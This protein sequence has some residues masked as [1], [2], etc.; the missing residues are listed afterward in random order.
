MQA[1]A[2]APLSPVAALAARAATVRTACG[3]GTAVWRVWGEGP[4]V[5]LLHGASG[6]WTHWLRNIPALAARFRVIVPDMPGYGDSAAPPEPTAECLA[7][8]LADG[9]D[10]VVGPAG[11]VRLAGF[12]C[13]G[14]VAGLVAARP[15]RRAR[16]LVLVGPNGLA[17]PCGEMAPLRRIDAGMSA[18][19]VREAHRANLTILMFG[20]PGRADDLAVSLHIDNVARARFRSAGIPESDLLLRA[21]PSVTARIAGIWG[22]R[23]A[24]AVPFVEERRRVLARFDPDLDFRIVPGAGHWAPYEAPERVNT[25]MTEMLR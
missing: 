1:P 5:V 25:F 3:D 20:D 2:V 8:V 15:R 24:F 18:E 21:L 4:P 14:I 10:T 7:Q 22:E 6:S 9:I 12:S 16:T 23:D 19:E 17:L 13:G 11:E